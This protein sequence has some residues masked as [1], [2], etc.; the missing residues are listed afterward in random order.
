METSG[1]T[2]RF[3]GLNVRDENEQ[4]GLNQVI[5]VIEDAESTIKQQI[6]ENNRLRA[7]LQIKDQELEI[8]KSDKPTVSM[9]GHQG[10]LV[11]HDSTVKNNDPGRQFNG[12]SHSAISRNN[13][14]LN[15]LPG[16]QRNGDNAGYSHPPSPYYAD[17][18]PG[19]YPM[20]GA[21][22]AHSNLH[23]QGLLAESSNSTYLWKQDLIQKVREHKEE[24]MLL[25]KQLT[26]Y[27]IR[28]AQLRNEKYLLEKRISNMR[29]AFDKQQQELADAAVKAL[30]Y[31]QDVIEE[32]VRLSYLLQDAHQE[33]STFVSSLLSVLAEYSLQPSVPD[34]LS[35]VT[36]VKVLFKHL[37]EKLSITEAK[38]KESQYQLIPFRTD[39]S[40]PHFAPLSPRRSS[41]SVPSSRK[42]GLEIVSQPAYPPGNHARQNNLSGAVAENVELDGMGR[43]SPT[44]SRNTGFHDVSTQVAVTQDGMH[45]SQYHGETTSRETKLKDPVSSSVMFEPDSD[46]QYGEREPPVNWGSGTSPYANTLVETSSY[47]PYLQTV[48]EEPSSS[49][50]EVADDDPL[51]A[52]RDLQISGEPYPGSVLMAS[53][54]SI[55]GTTCCNFE[56]VR[57]LED[58]SFHYIDGAKEP[59]YLVTADDVNTTLA[60][61]I[62]PLDDRKRKGELVKVFVNEHRKITCD[63]EMQSQIDRNLL[64]GQASYSVYLS[65]GYPDKWEKASLLVKREGYTI[66]S[67]EPRG[68]VISDKFLPLTSVSIT[69]GLPSEFS[70]ITANGTEHVLLAENIPE[71]SSLRDLIVLTLRTFINKRG[72]PVT[73]STARRGSAGY[74]TSCA[75]CMRLDESLLTLPACLLG[76]LLARLLG[77]L[78]AWLLGELLIPVAA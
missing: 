75:A 73:P 39:I 62:Q 78:P 74:A 26:D 5:K 55:N 18:S 63:P 8:L 25:K 47:S 43:Y 11:F 51:P 72:L 57:H 22:D 42:N 50:S 14:I 9:F 13:D 71:I 28:E 49:F 2:D 36:N 23:G 68:S 61:E 64:N 33:R 53:G 15:S 65:T 60:L 12:D 58:G 1:L 48:P 30:T 29:M 38:V 4:S 40:S 10:T 67:M 19:R 7:E 37:Q 54:H 27:S 56:W 44:A 66:T 41:G 32:N 52:I 45:M 76:V 3:S 59:K 21:Y 6:D 35:I 34:A 24:I 46:V 20:D 17:V 69:T 16:G 70:I 77:V 31:R